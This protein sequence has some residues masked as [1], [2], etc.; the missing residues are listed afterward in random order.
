MVV[1]MLS[2]W[3]LPP[4]SSAA[5]SSCSLALI[6]RFMSPRFNEEI[7]T[8]LLVESHS[9]QCFWCLFS[10]SAVSLAANFFLSEEVILMM[11]VL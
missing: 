1:V 2:S 4:S 7:T 6:G 11:V 3:V 10:V 5:L 9:L 8:D